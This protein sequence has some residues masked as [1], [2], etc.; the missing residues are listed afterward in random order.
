ML[1]LLVTTH[2]LSRCQGTAGK[3]SFTDNVKHRKVSRTKD[4]YQNYIYIEF[5]VWEAVNYFDL[6]ESRNRYK[7]KLSLTHTHTGDS[8]SDP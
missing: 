7:G 2:S 4:R 6:S 3:V 8:S 1:T 5:A